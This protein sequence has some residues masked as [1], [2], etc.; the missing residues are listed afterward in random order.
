MHATL[1]RYWFS[2]GQHSKSAFKNQIHSTFGLDEI[3]DPKLLK[4]KF[5]DQIDIKIESCF[6]HLHGVYPIA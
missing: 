1:A 5:I 3:Y 6:Q 4:R 2:S